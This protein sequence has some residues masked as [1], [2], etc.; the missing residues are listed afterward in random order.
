[1]KS[2]KCK[3]EKFEKQRQARMRNSKHTERP[4]RKM[5]RTETDLPELAGDVV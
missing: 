4:K 5:N 1:M 3:M 2:I